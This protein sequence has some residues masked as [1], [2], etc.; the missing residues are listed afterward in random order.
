MPSKSPLEQVSLISIMQMGVDSGRLTM[1]KDGSF[2]TV[3]KSPVI[4]SFSL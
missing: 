1:G 3:T 4:M 2:D